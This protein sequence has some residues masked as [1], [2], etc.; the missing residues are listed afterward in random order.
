M[1]WK[2]Q[3]LIMHPIS[4]IPFINSL[5]RGHT[6]K[7]LVFFGN[8][9]NQKNAVTRKIFAHF[10]KIL[11]ILISKNFQ[12]SHVF[13][14][15]SFLPYR[16]PWKRLHL[17]NLLEEDCL[18]WPHDLMTKCSYHPCQHSRQHIA[19]FLK[20]SAN[21]P[22]KFARIKKMFCLNYENFCV[23]PRP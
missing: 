13:F 11:G 15:N 1:E 10:L 18:C 3:R 5:G 9:S 14:H 12:R 16:S 7:I 23:W 20:I 2:S 17:C 21:F 4:A 8:S 22:Y 19:K 6:Q